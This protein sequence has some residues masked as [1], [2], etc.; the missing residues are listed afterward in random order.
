MFSWWFLVEA[1]YMSGKKTIFDNQHQINVPQ[2]ITAVTI[3][4]GSASWIHGFKFLHSLTHLGHPTRVRGNQSFP[5]LFAWS[6]A[7]ELFGNCSFTITKVLGAWWTLNHSVFSHQGSP[8]FLEGHKTWLWDSSSVISPPSS[9]SFHNLFTVILLI[10]LYPSYA[11]SSF[12][13][14]PVQSSQF[15]PCVLFYLCSFLW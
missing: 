9:S 3:L 13:P 1:R 7:V 6:W 8:T 14:S 4:R 5:W 12:S 11:L 2:F 15:V 10:L